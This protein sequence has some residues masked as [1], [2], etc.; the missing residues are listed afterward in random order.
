MRTLNR[1]LADL[2]S[3]NH[4]LSGIYAEL[5]ESA[6]PKETAGASFDRGCRWRGSGV[7]APEPSVSKPKPGSSNDTHRR[8]SIVGAGQFLGNPMSQSDENRPDPAADEL[9][10]FREVNR[11]TNVPRSTWSSWEAVGLAPKGLKLGPRKTLWQRAD[12]LA[13]ISSR[14]SA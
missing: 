10:P 1:T 3:Q 5:V 8:F 6:E 7:A 11:I 12:V 9:I 4:Q 13:F 14:K 2:D